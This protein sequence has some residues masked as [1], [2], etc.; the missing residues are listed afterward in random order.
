MNTTQKP[1]V[2]DMEDSIF[3]S[4][5]FN[6]YGLE[7]DKK[8]SEIISHGQIFYGADFI[9]KYENGT[10]KLI[11]QTVRNGEA[12]KSI[13]LKGKTDRSIRIETNKMFPRFKSHKPRIISISQYFEKLN[14]QNGVY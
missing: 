2:I 5:M 9:V 12:T 6:M 11:I 13:D 4:R 3:S 10:Y 7:I 8:T 1:I 14:Q